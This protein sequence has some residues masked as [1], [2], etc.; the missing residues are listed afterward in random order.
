[1]GHVNIV[2]LLLDAGA[3][4]NV[5]DKV[6]VQTQALMLWNLPAVTLPYVCC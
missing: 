3:G 5:Q 2:K 6:S 4:M 1:M